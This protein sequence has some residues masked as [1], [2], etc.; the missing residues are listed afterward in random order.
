MST[1]SVS[2]SSAEISRNSG[3]QTAA[4][5]GANQQT[6]AP[7]SINSIM[8]LIYPSYQAQSSLS[9]EPEAGAHSEVSAADN[10]LS[11]A[12]AISGAS[13]T[14]AASNDEPELKKVKLA[15]YTFFK[16]H[17]FPDS[18]KQ[19]QQMMASGQNSNMY[20]Q[21]KKLE[22]RIGGILCC[23]VCLDL[24]STAIYQ[25]NNGHLMCA[26]CF[27]HL[28]ADARLKDEQ[29]TCPNCRCEISKTSCSRNLA[30]EKTL[31]ELPAT[32]Q[33]CSVMFARNRLEE[34]QKNECFE[35]P[36]KCSYERIGCMWEGPFHELS[37]HCE[38]CAHPNRPCREIM[39]FLKNK[40]ASLEEEEHSLSSLVN[41]LSYEKVC[42]ND[43][44]FKQYRTDEIT[45]KLY[46][47]TNRFSAFFNQWVLKARVND[48]QKNPNLSLN[49]HISFQLILKSRL[50][51]SQPSIEIK[52]CILKGPFGEV[53]INPR[54][55]TFEFNPNKLETDFIKLDI[56]AA[57]CNKLLSSKIINFRC[58]MFQN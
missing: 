25:C 30:V 13:A 49:R 21:H 2:T 10:N 9:T 23:T 12:A 43:L 55:Q 4:S 14:L 58:F 48:N 47:E 32:C 26:G 36:V 52:F 38:I 35:R 34:H 44:Q 28:L 40:D 11:V 37:E 20:S 42:F 19:Q 8:N 24:P 46:F 33:F 18:L 56:D 6:Q 27:S 5:D 17:M 50:S 39:T 15:H 57:D 1:T 29:S 31:S 7:G 41:I 51:S 45:P 54:V 16:N 53:P 22:E 3:T